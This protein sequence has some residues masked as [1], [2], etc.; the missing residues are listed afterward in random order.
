[1][2]IKRSKIPVFEM[3]MIGFLPSFLK[4]MIYRL[5]G[6][7]IGKGVH[8][9][10]GSIIIGEEVSI[11]DYSKVGFI[12]VIR[13]RKI[14]LERFVI[15]GSMTMIDTEEVIIGEDTRINENVIIGGIRTPESSIRIGKR[16]IVM[17]YSCLNPTKPIVIGND[18]GIGGH[19]LLFT[20]G[21]WLNQLDGFPVTFAPIT[22]GNNVW[23]PWRVFIMPGVTIGNEVVIGA[24]SLISSNLPSNV[25][26]AGSPAKIWKENYPPKLSEEKRLAI[27]DLIFSEFQTYLEHNH[28]TVKKNDIEDGL[29]FFVQKKK[30]TFC[31]VFLKT[32]PPIKNTLPPQ[33]DLL[34][35]HQGF[36]NFE[37]GAT[38]TLNI[39]K[40]TRKGTSLLGEEFVK[41]VSRH[42]IRFERMD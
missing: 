17:E 16:A 27:L 3:V 18:S 1:M 22:I 32:R 7:K 14:C 19:C 28:I 13:A 24:N 2:L 20:H 36:E 5:K 6:Y 25:M 23:L 12:T 41:Y 34:I 4:K 38:M 8:I 21:S 39:E 33:I 29:C 42:G 9:G 26:A 10:L 31:L 40:K 15:I 11:G 30:Q 35:L 37:L